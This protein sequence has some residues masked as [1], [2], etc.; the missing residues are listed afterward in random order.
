[1]PA[2]NAVPFI[3]VFSRLFALLM[4]SIMLLAPSSA[5]AQTPNK[6]QLLVN[7]TAA[8]FKMAYRH[9]TDEHRA[10]YDQLSNALAA[11]NSAPRGEENDKLL[12]DWLRSTISRSMPGSRD[13]LPPL[14]EFNR[15]F[16]EITAAHTPDA[17]KRTGDPF[18]DD[19]LDAAQLE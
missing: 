15:P 14:P 2:K 9:N 1:M 18:A 5:I 12:A 8:Q 10:R 19:P 17:D 7:E 6:L 11:W 3:D 13:P 16:K 4:A